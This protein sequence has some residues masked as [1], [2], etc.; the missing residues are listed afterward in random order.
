MRKRLHEAPALHSRDVP[1]FIRQEDEKKT[2]LQ[3][4]EQ[5]GGTGSGASPG[6]ALVAWHI[7]K[8]TAAPP[9]SALVG[10]GMTR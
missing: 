7:P 2:T 10:G 3:R 6:A 8:C 5:T 1:Y 9:D 4:R